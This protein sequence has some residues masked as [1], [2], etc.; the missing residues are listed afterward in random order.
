[1]TISTR[2]RDELFTTNQSTKRV[3]DVEPASPQL[4][5][6]PLTRPPDVVTMKP[7]KPKKKPVATKFEADSTKH[8]MS[9]RHGLP[10]TTDEHDRFLQG[11][12]RYP[13]GPWKA[14]AAFVGTRTPRQTMTHAQKYRQKIQRRRR[15]LLTS[16]RRPVPMTSEMYCGLVITTSVKDCDSV[17][18]SP[19]SADNTFNAD[20]RMAPLE[21]NWFDK[22]EVNE[23][24]AAF[25]S[26]LEVYDPTL[27][28]MDEEEQISA[29]NVSMEDSI[30]I[31]F[32]LGLTMILS[33]STVR[34]LLKA[35]RAEV[36]TVSI[37]AKPTTIFDNQDVSAP[38]TQYIFK[39]KSAISSSQSI[40]EC[41]KPRKRY[42]DFYAL[43]NTLRRTRK[44]WEKSCFKQGEAFEEA[45]EILQQAVGSEF[46]RKH[47]RCDTK[48]II[49]QRR[50]QLMDYMRT[51][52]AAYTEL[53]VLLGAPGNFKCNFI[54]DI[55]CLNKVFVEIERFLEI[56]PK[57]KDI[58]A[59]LTR[60]VMALGDVKLDPN[61]ENQV[62]Q[63]CI[64]LSENNPSDDHFDGDAEM[65]QLPCA[66]IFHEGCIVH[67]LQCGSTC[68]MC[69]RTVG[70]SVTNVFVTK[71]FVTNAFV[72]YLMTI[73]HSVQQEFLD[74]ETKNLICIPCHPTLSSDHNSPMVSSA[75]RLRV[76]TA[77][78]QSLRN[79]PPSET[80]KG[81]RW[82]EDEHERFLLGMELFKAGPWKKIA[83]VVGTRDA[84]QTMSHAQKYRQ[85][86]KRRKLGL[87]I[88]EI[89][90]TSDTSTTKR[91]RRT[92]STLERTSGSEAA[93][94][95][96][97]NARSLVSPRGQLPREALGAGTT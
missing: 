11:L 90:V 86:I 42:S 93:K 66:H 3:T 91:M 76:S 89:D 35:R 4:I 68:P 47:V 24:D 84:R 38:Y 64:C 16:S 22:V 53:E 97:G 23:L 54:D 59:K 7:K 85:K 30:S 57:R 83:S 28:P 74:D 94:R 25:Q 96:V 19:T 26:F 1:M 63:C 40:K 2:I 15:G 58:E 72:V 6:L 31:V 95:V 32:Q 17:A 67:W 70:N 34:R 29:F 62:M 88:P 81:E 79:A 14:I 80:T 18:E 71:V 73:T 77:A 78:H 27:F 50:G 36:A 10:W 61:R 75:V 87:P 33:Q 39:L 56:P 52:L 13:S 92:A 51:L 41:W 46:P 43:Y 5:R 12:E 82:T 49:Q 45:L 44:Q 69:R 21:S 20:E 37:T 55:T 65:A 8:Q 48:A 60:A 9:H